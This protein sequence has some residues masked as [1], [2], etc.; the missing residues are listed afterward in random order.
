MT[1]GNYK[2]VEKK[3]ELMKWYEHFAPQNMNKP[4]HKQYI[5]IDR[6]LWDVVVKLLKEHG[7]DIKF[8]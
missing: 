2:S 8:L 5:K 4:K 6:E 7:Y 1:E 3:R